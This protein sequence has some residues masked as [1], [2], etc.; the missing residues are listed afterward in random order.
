VAEHSDGLGDEFGVVVP[1]RL[2]S[3]AGLP[4]LVALGK[5]SV[6]IDTESPSACVCG[7]PV[8]L[9]LSA[10]VAAAGAMATGMGPLTGAPPLY[11]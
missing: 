6:E 8:N 4:V 3:L 9:P 11:P 1:V 7:P 10:G 2:K 5:R